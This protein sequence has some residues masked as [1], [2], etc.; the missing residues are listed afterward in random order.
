MREFLWKTSGG[1]IC[2]IEG[3]RQL[4]C[5]CGVMGLENLD[6]ANVLKLLKNIVMNYNV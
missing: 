3:K 2:L 5:Q 4:Y 1:V 6:F